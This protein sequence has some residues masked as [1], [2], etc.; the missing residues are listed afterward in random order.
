MITLVALFHI[1]VESQPRHTMLQWPSK[2]LTSG[3]PG[4]ISKVGLCYFYKCTFGYFF[5]KFKSNSS[6][7]TDLQVPSPWSE[8]PAILPFPSFFAVPISALLL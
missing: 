1:A 5:K 2:P 8:G 3:S 6:R 7:P 4:G